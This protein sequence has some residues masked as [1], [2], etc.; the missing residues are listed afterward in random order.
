MAIHGD[1]SQQ[2]RDYVMQEF[3]AG[4]VA[5]MI[6]TDVAARGIGIYESTLSRSRSRSS[7]HLLFSKWV[8]W[9]CGDGCYGGDAISAAVATAGDNNVGWV[10]MMMLVLLS[11]VFRWLNPLLLLQCLCCCIFLVMQETRSINNKFVPF[12]SW[13]GK[14]AT[15]EIEKKSKLICHLLSFPS[16]RLRVIASREVEWKEIKKTDLGITSTRTQRKEE[17]N[18]LLCLSLLYSPPLPP[19]PYL[20]G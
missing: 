15:K 12:G 20:D 11:L 6:A 18:S 3:R 14:T 17:E 16:L 1:K 2:E 5:I 19:P 13:I 8:G 9:L 10:T 7:L 4:R